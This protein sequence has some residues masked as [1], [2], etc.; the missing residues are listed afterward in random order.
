[1]NPE[2]LSLADEPI[3]SRPLTTP[4]GVD[5]EKVAWLLLLVGAVVTRFWDLGLRAM[6]HD[7]AQHAIYSFYLYDTG[8]YQ[9]D[10]LLHGPLLFHLNALFYFLFGASDFS[11]RLAPALSGLG[12]ILLIAC[13]RRYIGRTGALVAA[14]L[15]VLSPTML[16]YSRYIRNDVYIALFVMVWIYAAFRYL[17][18]RTPRW[19][20][21]MVAAMALAFTTKENSFIFGA[22]SG[23]FFALLGLGRLLWSRKKDSAPPSSD[24]R[25]RAALDLSL[26][27]LTLVLPFMTPWGY[28]ITGRDLAGYAQSE[29]LWHNLLLLGVVTLLSGLLAAICFGFKRGVDG[30]NLRLWVRLMALFWGVQILLFTTFFTNTQK[31][32]VSGV[33]GSL[34]YWLTQHEVGRGSQPWFYYLILSTVYEFLALFLCLA[35]IWSPSLEDQDLGAGFE[36]GSSNGSRVQ[37]LE[38][39]RKRDSEALPLFL[40][41][42]G[43]LQL[44]RL[45]R[46]RRKNAVAPDACRFADVCSGWLVVWPSGESDSLELGHQQQSIGLDPVSRPDRPARFRPTQRRSF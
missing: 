19:L 41:V 44:G 5:R 14:L 10:P 20:W 24:L 38:R 32:L 27:M 7:E 31:G 16:C 13:L 36:S 2:T 11:A 12:V 43:A 42:L 39:R 35:A 28:F 30:I 34:G 46:S 23:A 40:D 9:H 33:V 8:N 6:S 18:T 1:M 21:M 45:L 4:A 25:D 15:V 22:T 37:N 26:L 17:E 29:N 3:L